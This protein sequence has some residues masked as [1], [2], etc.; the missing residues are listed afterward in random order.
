MNRLK[1]MKLSTKIMGLGLVVAVFMAAMYVYLVPY[2]GG[3]IYEEKQLKTRHVV[4]TA[5][6]LIQHYVGLEKSGALT[7]EAAQEAAKK[8]VAG[9]RYESNDYFWINDYKPDMIMH[10]MKP[11][12]DGTSLAQNKD[13]NGKFLFVEMSKV[14]QAQGAGFVDYDWP[15]PGET[16]PVPKVSY[17][18]GIPEWKWIVGSG[19]YVDDVSKEVNRLILT[20]GLIV[21]G[22]FIVSMVLSWLMA[23][24]LTKPLLRAMDN[25]TSGAEQVNAAASSLSESSQNLA[26]GASEQAATVEETSAALEQMTSMTHQ[27]NTLTKDTEGLMNENLKNP[28]NPWQ[29]LWGSTNG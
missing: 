5:A 14:V 29:R 12:L 26:E 22:V 1:R 20:I 17:V 27:T 25:L 28:T 4:E 18:Q 11:E 10:P 15:K 19:I 2:F 7:L 8:A 21:V 23:R 9:L 3:R 13:P 16:K 24:S 6:S